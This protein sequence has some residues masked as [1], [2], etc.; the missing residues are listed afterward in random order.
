MVIIIKNT[1]NYH[2]IINKLFIYLYIIT[3]SILNKHFMVFLFYRFLF[4]QIAQN[5][6]NV[7]DKAIE[8]CKTPS[9]KSELSISKI[10]KND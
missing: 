5:A 1:G 3:H 7:I 9:V 2:Y 6:T 8:I 10:M 4:Q